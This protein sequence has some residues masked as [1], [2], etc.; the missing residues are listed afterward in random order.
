MLSE[1]RPWPQVIMGTTH[2]R[3]LEDLGGDSHAQ[4]SRSYCSVAA[5]MKAQM[6]ELVFSEAAP[7]IYQ[8]HDRLHGLLSLL[9]G[10]GAAVHVWMMITLHGI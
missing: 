7:T 2:C 9:P 3:V 6:D 10:D 8:P 5:S 1:P 4:K